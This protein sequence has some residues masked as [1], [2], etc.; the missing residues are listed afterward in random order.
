MSLPRMVAEVLV[1]SLR[2]VGG[3][4]GRLVYTL[5]GAIESLRA[6]AS[7]AGASAGASVMILKSS[8]IELA[9]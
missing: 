3:S 4:F 2:G 1:L 5:F 8:C 7:R 6:Y 9:G